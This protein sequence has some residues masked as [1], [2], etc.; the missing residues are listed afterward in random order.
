[1]RDPT[2]TDL[3]A[4][5]HA[6][7][8]HEKD[9]IPAKFLDYVWKIPTFSS[10]SLSFIQ[11]DIML[12]KEIAIC[13]LWR[14]DNNVLELTSE[15]AIWPTL[16]TWASQQSSSI[17]AIRGSSQS[18]KSLRYLSCQV[19][20]HLHV[21]KYAAASVLNNTDLRGHFK[22]LGAEEVL[23]QIA[24]Q[25][26]KAITTDLTISLLGETL[27]QFCAAST[28]KDW[29]RLLE[30]MMQK[31]TFFVVVID[32]SVLEDH[33]K[34]AGLWINQFNEMFNR[35]ADKCIAC[36]KVMILTN[37]EI[38]V[39]LGDCLQVHVGAKAIKA[40]PENSS[41]LARTCTYT[42][43]SLPFFIPKPTR[44]YHAN[45]ARPSLSLQDD[46]GMQVEEVEQQLLVT[47]Q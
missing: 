20:N 15:A 11:P 44:I 31:L 33:A 25:L 46:S 19:V 34:E 41:R 14:R 24:C 8:D 13:G 1:L 47:T 45:D 32:A 27:Q 10:P 3:L 21:R 38:D 30:L 39:T 18:T 42:D 5:D 7:T 6:P 40:L 26:L 2:L 22:S 17:V 43:F 9:E 29:F 37:R 12:E 16:S 23:R 4:I 35:A 36:T 28:A